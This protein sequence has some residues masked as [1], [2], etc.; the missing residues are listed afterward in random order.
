M[1]WSIKRM[2]GIGKMKAKGRT[3]VKANAWMRDNSSRP[4]P[5]LRDYLRTFANHDIDSAYGKK[6]RVYGR[7]RKH[8]R[9]RRG[10]Y[11]S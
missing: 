5:H 3:R 1:A 2:L 11:R 10:R 8:T 7:A 6:P 9:V 4:G